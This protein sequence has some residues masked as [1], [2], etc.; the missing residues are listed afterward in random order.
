[1]I[2]ILQGDLTA[3][4]LDAIVNAANTDLKLG[5]GVAGAIR[6][7]GGPTIQQECDAHGPVE[8]GGAALTGAGGLPAKHVIHAAGMHLGGSVTTRSLTDATQNSLDLAERHKL[9]SLAF[10][11]IGTG[12]GGYALADCA[13]VMLTLADEHLRRPGVSL[14][15]IRFVLFDAPA[16][17]AFRQAAREL[18][19]ETA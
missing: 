6:K 18:G 7:H 8:L 5:S 4:A 17:E 3:Q 15:E 1:M 14:K 19:I 11:A 16:C 2:R 12:V 9:V 13:R 10:P